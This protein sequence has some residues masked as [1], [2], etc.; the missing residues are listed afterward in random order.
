M[1]TGRG[2]NKLNPSGLRIRRKVSGSPIRCVPSDVAFIYDGGNLIEERDLE[3]SGAVLA[4]YYYADDG[5]ELVAG[6]FP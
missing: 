3:N 4:R 6:I 2:G 1:R 5:D